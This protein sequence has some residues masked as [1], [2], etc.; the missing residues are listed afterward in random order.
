[1]DMTCEE[2]SALLDEKLGALSNTLDKKLDKKL[3]EI[4]RQL[5]NLDDRIGRQDRRLSAI[6]NFPRLPVKQ[7]NRLYASEPR[8][9]CLSQ[10]V[11]LGYAG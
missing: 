4:K 9:M 3:D 6:E 7:P 5:V 1:M 11:K 2:L 8:S 10:Y